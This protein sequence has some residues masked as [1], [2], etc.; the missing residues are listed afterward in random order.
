MLN[1]IGLKNTVFASPVTSCRAQLV[2]DRRVFPLGLRA[3]Q[4]QSNFVADSVINRHQT[5]HR[6][7]KSA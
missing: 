2:H 7:N 5:I 6:S 3:T 1:R 4:A